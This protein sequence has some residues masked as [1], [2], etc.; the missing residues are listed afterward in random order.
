[1]ELRIIDRPDN[2]TQ[3]ELMAK[4]DVPW[5]NSVDEALQI[6]AKPNTR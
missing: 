4:L 1:M 5:A 6:L 2:I 3:V